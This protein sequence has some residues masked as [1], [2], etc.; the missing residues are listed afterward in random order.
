MRVRFNELFR[1]S[2]DGITPRVPIQIGVYVLNPEME[3]NS[4]VDLRRYAGMDVCVVADRVTQRQVILGFYT[5]AMVH[6]APVEYPAKANSFLS[7][8]TQQLLRM[9]I[10]SYLPF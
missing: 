7:R 4:P 6:E 8:T 10:M 5:D 9:R 2:E 3:K 1:V